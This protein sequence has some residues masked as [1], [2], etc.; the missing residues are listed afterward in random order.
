ML[1]LESENLAAAMRE[2]E[3]VR[4]VTAALAKLTKPLGLP[5]DYLSLLCTE[6]IAKERGSKASGKVQFQITCAATT[7]A[8]MDAEAE[9][10]PP[11]YPGTPPWASICSIPWEAIAPEIEDPDFPNEKVDPDIPGATAKRQCA[12]NQSVASLAPASKA[13]AT[14]TEGTLPSAKGKPKSATS[15]GSALRELGH[16]PVYDAPTSNTNQ[17]AMPSAFVGL[18]ALSMATFTNELLGAVA[19]AMPPRVSSA[20]P[21]RMLAASAIE[22]ETPTSDA[23]SRGGGR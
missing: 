1:A 20:V 11:P 6:K 15:S 3:K 2:S 12:D 21:P 17:T 18:G 13:A 10:F 7:V 22:G 14:Q 5:S 4:K 19:D 9:P 8:A 23:A 16:R